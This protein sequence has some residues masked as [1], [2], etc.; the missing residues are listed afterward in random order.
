[1][2]AALADAA[3]RR[4]RKKGWRSY[5]TRNVAGKRLPWVLFVRLVVLTFPST[6]LLV[7][8]LVGYTP[9]GRAGS[10]ASCLP[11]LPRSGRGELGGDHCHM[12]RAGLVD[13]GLGSRHANGRELRWQTGS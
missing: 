4:A 5:L 2:I 12:R 13:A 7:I 10:S 11:R 8:D 6:S 9:I 3:G 1:L